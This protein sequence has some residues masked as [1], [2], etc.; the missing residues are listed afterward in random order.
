MTPMSSTSPPPHRASARAHTVRHL[1]AL[2]ACVA[3]WTMAAAPAT[4]TQVATAE[5]IRQ[6]FRDSGMTVLTFAGYSGA[7]YEDNARMLGE[8]ESILRKHEPKKTIVNIGGTA[9]GIG[10][11]YKLA[12]SMGFQTTGIVSTQARDNKVALSPSVDRV[13]FV[14]DAS[15]GGLVPGTDKLSPTSQAMVENSDVIVAIGGGDVARDELAA[16]RALGKDVRFIPAD[17]NHR[18]AIDAAHREGSPHPASFRGTAQGI[19]SQ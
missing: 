16:A 1:L 4:V 12:R 9:E 19:F 8:A 5:E 6:F 13:F 15:W 3:G 2:A 17:M 7:G 14:T 10:A 18:K 11:V